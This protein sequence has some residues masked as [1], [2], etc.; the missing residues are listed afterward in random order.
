MPRRYSCSTTSLPP[1][2][3]RP[4]GL[5]SPPHDGF[6]L[7]A[8][9]HGDAL[10][11][12]H[13]PLASY[14]CTIYR[15]LAPRNTP[16]KPRLAPRVPRRSCLPPRSRRARA[17]Q[18]AIAT[19]SPRQIQPSLS[20]PHYPTRACRPDL[21]RCSH[22]R[23][24]H[25]HGVSGGF[26]TRP[27]A[28]SLASGNGR[29]GR[30]FARLASLASS[31]G[32]A[33]GRGTKVGMLTGGGDAPGLNG[34]IRAVTTKCDQRLRLRGHGLKRGWK[35]LLD[36]DEDTVMP[37]SVDTYAT[38]CRKAARSWAPRARTPTRMRGT[39]RRSSSRWRSSA[40]DA[41]VAI[42]GDDTLVWPRGSTT[43]SGCRSWDAP[44]P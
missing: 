40:I 1:T 13:I 37:L 12:R 6:A 21:Q 27:G 41:L 3:R 17:R 35:S 7:L 34:V 31:E 25:P 39:P 15:I 11:C 38:S 5:A 9:A 32:G 8:N 2:H 23:K 36:P 24:R 30:S 22:A 10:G 16:R 28:F 20:M 26:P 42:G 14:E 18:P 29:S 44:R 33:N 19:G 43:T 4:V